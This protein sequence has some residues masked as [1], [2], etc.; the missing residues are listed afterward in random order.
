MHC[1]CVRVRFSSWRQLRSLLPRAYDRDCAEAHRPSC[2]GKA[3]QGAVAPACICMQIDVDGDDHVSVYHPLCLP[4]P[5]LVHAFAMGASSYRG[6]TRRCPMG[7]DFPQHLY[8]ND[9]LCDRLVGGQSPKAGISPSNPKNFPAGA[10]CVVKP[11][12]PMSSC[13][14]HSCHAQRKPALNRARSSPMSSPC[15]LAAPGQPVR[16]RPTALHSGPPPRQKERHHTVLAAR[17]TSNVALFA[18]SSAGA[19]VGRA[20]S[21]RVSARALGPSRHITAPPRPPRLAAEG[22][23]TACCR[24]PR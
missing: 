12:S 4:L 11:L 1:M 5:T 16:K 22:P 17:P 20:R 23:C 7:G 6:R 3:S 24:R 10:G 21:T 2:L 18:T 13:R 9:R 19:G 15:L 14:S 8:I